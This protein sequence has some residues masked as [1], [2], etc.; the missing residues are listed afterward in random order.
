MYY[1]VPEQS[2]KGRQMFIPQAPELTLLHH[3]IS[4]SGQFHA[5]KRMIIVAAALVTN[6]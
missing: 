1:Y 6:P 4:S 5:F 3:T 2:V